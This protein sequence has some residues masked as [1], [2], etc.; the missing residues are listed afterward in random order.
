MSWI[1]G[2][3]L[4]IR[5]IALRDASITIED[6]TVSPA[7]MSRLDAVDVSFRSAG[8]GRERSVSGTV[9]IPDADV[10][11]A[12]FVLRGPLEAS[13]D[14]DDV[15]AASGGFALDLTDAEL[16]YGADFAKPSGVP[17]TIRGA[18][19]R[20]ADGAIGA[21]DL[22]IVLRNLVA[23]GSLRTGA[24][25][26]LELT[27]APFEIEGWETLVPVLGLVQPRGR[28][29]ITE[30]VAKSRFETTR[31]RFALDALGMTL[32]DSAPLSL[33]GEVVLAGASI[34]SRDAKLLI[35][36]EPFVVSPKLD[37]LGG[38]P[39]FEVRFETDGA[40]SDALLAA[41]VDL[42][43]RLHGPLVARGTLRG[44]LGGAEPFLETLVGDIDFG[45]ANGRIVGASILE[46]ALG[47]LGKRVAESRRANSDA[48]WERFYSDEFENLGGKVRL[49]RGHLVSE[50]VT[51]AYR[52]YGVTLEGPMR[53]PD[54]DLDLRG[55]ISLGPEV[56]RELARAFNAPDE[57]VPEKRELALQSVRGTPTDPKV[58]VSSNSVATLAA[59][60]VKE[61]QREDLKRAAEKELGPGSGEIIDRGL[62][63]LEGILGGRR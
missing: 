56:D 21:D 13:L 26:I 43:D 49:S 23:S 28:V 63:A 42:P 3:V 58:Q 8:S 39:R 38:D 16:R 57:Y 45:I 46:A 54:F 18:L 27:A 10:A 35:A 52:D 6:R 5:S 29:A 55:S 47:S 37:D 7:A 2:I 41:L 24:D 20:D 4:G 50:P 9:E 51:L 34:F 48:A 1:A 44:P 31:G 53:L 11:L 22:E 15:L 14:S 30:L 19:T 25:P 12:G 40:S 32:P 33:T 60:Y 62:D 36:G 61:T 17:A 59:H